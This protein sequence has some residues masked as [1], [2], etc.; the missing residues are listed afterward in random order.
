ML[1]WIDKLAVKAADDLIILVSPERDGEPRA[2]LHKPALI[3]ATLRC[4]LVDGLLFPSQCRPPKLIVLSVLHLQCLINEI[5]QLRSKKQP[6]KS[7]RH[8]KNS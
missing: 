7:G 2:I 8:A 4:R 5:A 6:E 3:E 1:K